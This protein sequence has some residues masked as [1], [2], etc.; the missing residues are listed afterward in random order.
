MCFICGYER[1]VFEK[2]EKKFSDHK[3]VEHNLW[4]Y[5]FYLFYLKCKNPDDFT[6]I[7]YYINEKFNSRNTD[8]FP[9]RNTKYISKS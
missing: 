9:I 4:S 3:E 1:T 6:G 8:W 7:E 2:Q 5:A